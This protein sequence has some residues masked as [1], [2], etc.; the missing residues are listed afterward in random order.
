MRQWVLS[1]PKRLRNFM[2]RDGVVPSMVLRIFLQVI[3]QSLQ[4][5][6]SG[7][8]QVDKSALHISDVAYIHRF[9]SSLSE[10]VHSH[11]C[12]IDGV[13]ELARGEGKGQT[14]ADNPVTPP[15]INFHDASEIDEAFVAQVQATLRRRILQ[16]FVDRGL[17]EYFE[18]KVILACQHSGCLR[19]RA[20]PGGFSAWCISSWT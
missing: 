13:S 12:V 7:A 10:P 19:P 11:L 9:G 14:A 6:W 5:D 20:L 2:Q 18:T 16:A 15:N 3:A 1:V 8:S 4:A 17:L